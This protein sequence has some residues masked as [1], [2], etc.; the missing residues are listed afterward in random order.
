MCDATL[1]RVFTLLGKRWNGII[2]ATLASGSIG[3]TDLRRAVAGISDS[4]LSDR[5]SELAKSDIV[6]RIVDTG[7]PVSVEYRLTPA[8]LAL[9]PALDGL[10]SWASANWPGPPSR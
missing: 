7:P 8:G 9:L 10:S 2:I 1:S 3:F 5:L 6:E 4:M